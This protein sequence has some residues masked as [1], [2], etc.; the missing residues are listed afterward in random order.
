MLAFLLFFHS[1][2]YNISFSSFQF[3]TNI[4][5]LCFC[6]VFVLTIRGIQARTPL[7]PAQQK[8]I[9]LKNGQHYSPPLSLKLRCERGQWSWCQSFSPA[10][11]TLLC[12][13]FR[14]NCS[15]Y[16]KIGACRHGDRCSR[17]HNKP[18]FSQVTFVPP[19]HLCV[20]NCVHGFSSFTGI[21][22]FNAWASVQRTLRE[23]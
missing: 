20:V 18:T 4:P 15:F 22:T 2:S 6:F 8:L 13:P 19:G 14:V 12:P 23:C 17:L 9:F 16:F 3:I 5:P 11:L 7:C 10:P 21:H 1:Q